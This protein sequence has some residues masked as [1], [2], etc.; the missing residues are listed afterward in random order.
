MAALS[1]EVTINRGSR[2]GG[3]RNRAES[4]GTWRRQTPEHTKVGGA[5]ERN[6]ND[7]GR[8]TRDNCLGG[9]AGPID[10]ARL[11]T[12]FGGSP[13]GRSN[14]ERARNTRPCDCVL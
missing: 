2:K 9:R 8:K 12:T 14:R 5:C 6:S 4:C 1:G 7:G 3:R 10:R 11:L 13:G